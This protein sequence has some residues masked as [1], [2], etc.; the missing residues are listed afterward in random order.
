MGAINRMRSPVV[1]PSAVQDQNRNSRKEDD[2]QRRSALRVAAASQ[3][4]P[5][6]EGCASKS[7]GDKAAPTSCA[8]NLCGYLLGRVIRRYETGVMR[9]AV[10]AVKT[11]GKGLA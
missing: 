7:F 1:N 2:L 10:H 9:D 11:C 3:K 8:S 4:V 5:L 6:H